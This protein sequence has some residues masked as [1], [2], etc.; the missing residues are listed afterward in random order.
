MRTSTLT[1]LSML[2]ATAAACVDV[3]DLGDE[4]DELVGTPTTARPEV[5]RVIRASG[6]PCMGTL[7]A[8]AIVVTDAGCA[9]AHDATSEAP[10]IGARFEFIDATGQV[11]TVGIN[12]AVAWQRLSFVHL[13]TPIAAN[14][15]TPAAIS[16]LLPDNGAT[17]TV[18][19]TDPA[20]TLK[21]RI[22]YSAPS[23][24]TWD[25]VDRGGP[26]FHGPPA[27]ASDLALLSDLYKYD[28]E[29]WGTTPPTLSRTERL[30]D[31]WRQFEDKLHAWDGQDEVGFDRPGTD[32]A[33]SPNVTAAVCRAICEGE[34]QCRAFT[35]G[36]T[37]TCW[38]K[39]GRPQ[40]R[41]SAGAVSGLPRRVRVGIDV[42]GTVVSTST[43]ARADLCEAACGRDA[44]CR[45]W[46][47]FAPD[48]S[49]RLKSTRGTIL[50]NADVTSG[51]V[52]R[53]FEQ[54]VDR[55]GRDYAAD[56]TSEH[57]AC[58][59]LCVGDERCAAFTWDGISGLCW[60][61]TDVPG[62]FA[63]DHTISGV[64]RG[65]E[66][67]VDRPGGDFKTITLGTN[68]QRTPDI[69]RA[70]RCQTACARDAACK[71]WAI[72]ERDATETRCYLKSSVSARTVK[73]GIISGVKGLEFQ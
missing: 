5:G 7:V 18:F 2:A 67:D 11:R 68:T 3:P 73:Q 9:I 47:W 55:G 23:P 46:T 59:A 48:Q 4:V 64:R 26:H 71:A 69:N 54:L 49:C 62:A 27:G 37:G 20:T 53:D 31:Y 44:Q 14:L 22:V 65:V 34:P 21:Q 24:L 70:T 57:Q 66:A 56:P 13:A 38:R 36:P 33:S 8:P 43:Q 28:D 63:S 10:L 41:P 39:R 19:T 17:M 45:V 35:L 29:I 61:K 12:K 16:T 6:T 32:Y 42:V 1:L 25:T 50:V 40:L 15:A 72:S 60:R 58:A 30:L 51:F 52:D